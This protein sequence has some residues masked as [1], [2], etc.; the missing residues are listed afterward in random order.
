MR[1]KQDVLRCYNRFWKDGARV[2][3]GNFRG[4]NAKKCYQCETR[5]RKVTEKKR[6]Y[7]NKYSPHI[8]IDITL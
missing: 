8:I 4:R 2:Y 7:P 3:C 1:Q 6:F 5:L